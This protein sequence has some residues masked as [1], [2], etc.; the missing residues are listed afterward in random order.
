MVQNLKSCCL[1]THPPQ[2]IHLPLPHRIAL[3]SVQGL[4]HQLQVPEFFPVL[5]QFGDRKDVINFC[6]FAGVGTGGDHGGLSALHAIEVCWCEQSQAIG[7][8]QV[9]QQGLLHHV[10]PWLLGQRGIENRFLAIFR[11]VVPDEASRPL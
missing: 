9:S 1:L 2:Q 6:N 7:N 8:E 4:R 5:R 3:P 11:P 10:P